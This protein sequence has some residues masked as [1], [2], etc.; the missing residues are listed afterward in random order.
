MA[1]RSCPALFVSVSKFLFKHNHIICLC[2]G[3]I[4]FM[5]EWQSYIVAANTLW[6]TEPKVFI[7]WP[8][9]E[10]AYIP[11]IEDTETDH[12]IIHFSL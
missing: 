7:I 9:T 5:L 1:C 8:F 11:L 6:P 3:F 10:K 4:T 12:L 2:I